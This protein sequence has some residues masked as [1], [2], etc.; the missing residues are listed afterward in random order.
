MKSNQVLSFFLIAAIGGLSIAAQAQNEADLSAFLAAS[1]QDAS[2]LIS[3]YTAPAIKAISYGMTGGWYHTAKTH[4]KLGIDIGVTVNAVFTPS[5]DDYFQPYT[6]LSS[7]TQFAN[8]S[9]PSSSNAP[10]IFGPKESTIYTATYSPSTKIGPQSVTIN[11]PEGLD[12]RKNLGVSVVPVP[13][14]QIGIGLIK[15]TD[16]KIRFIP[17][18]N[19]AQT[20]LSMLGFGLL[21]DIKQYFPGVKLVP[22]DLSVLAAYNSFKGV[23]NLTSSGDPLRPT[24][25]DG[26]ATYTLNSWVA[27]VLISK[28]IAILT[29][30]AGVGYGSVS[31]KAKITG[32]YTITAVPA[33]SFNITDPVSFNLKNTS[34]KL[35]GGMR[36]N[37]GP[38]YFNGDYTVQKYS[39]LSVGM[40]LTIR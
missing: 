10:T 15:N 26:K 11:G 3:A 33:G 4:K 21:H 32:T 12:L 8:T 17:K 18:V 39:A 34:A 5:S 22:F 24:S 27:Q 28:K 6:F 1:K 40:G 7:S 19:G 30:Y 36:F 31:T 35:T 9:N 29:L 16:L 37:L 23:T 13:M 20:S 2:N 14:A 38:L 25:T